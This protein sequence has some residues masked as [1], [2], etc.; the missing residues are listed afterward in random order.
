MS[1]IGFVG[2]SGLMGHGMA[3]NLQLKGH[4][5]KL[6]LHRN[7]ERV[8]DLLDLGAVKAGEP[9]QLG[10]ECDIVFICVT[11]SPQ[12]EALFAGPEGL[13]GSARPGLTIVDCSTSEWSSTGKLRELCARQGVPFVDAPLARSAADAEAGRLNVMVGATDAEF[14]AVEP[15][16]RCFAENIVHVGPPGSGHAVKLIY[17][18]M[19]QAICTSTAEAFAVAKKV[20]VDLSKL[21]DVTAL[22][23]VNSGLFQAM[24]KGVDGDLKSLPFAIDNAR[25]DLRY[26]TRM[27]EG[28]AVPTW[29]GEAVHQTLTL[30]TA[31]GYGDEYVPSLLRAQEHVT[32]TRI[33]VDR[34]SPGPSAA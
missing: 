4:S 27:A 5:L 12:V 24:A 31:L 18:F 15:F 3:R 19:A 33:V 22:G 14:A 13:L 25:K 10:A 29:L 2:A 32:R 17:N 8:R 21:V 23:A 20:G 34:S 9:C 1:T 6:L 26:F 28:V 7:L 30:A 11:G 16:L